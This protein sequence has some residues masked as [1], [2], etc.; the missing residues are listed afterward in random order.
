MDLFPIAHR[1][2]VKCELLLNVICIY[3]LNKCW[4][5]IHQQV[6]I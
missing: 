4:K 3:K 1:L 6:G 5:L 2:V